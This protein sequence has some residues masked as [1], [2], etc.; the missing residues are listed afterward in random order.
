MKRLTGLMIV[1]LLSG[2]CRQKIEMPVFDLLLPDST[3]LNTGGIPSGK[4]TVLAFFSPTCEHCQDETIDLIKH[5]EA[6][7]DI[8]FYFVSIDSLSRIREF[9]SFYQLSKYKNI[10]IGRD[11][12]FSFPRLS[13]LHNIPS[14]QIYDRHKRLRVVING[15]F[16]VNTLLDKTKA[17]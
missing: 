5:M 14:S 17:W 4:I 9:T 8:Q 11:Y 16:T 12:T 1:L 10:T 2:A 3:L 15:G 7:R 13:G 6:V